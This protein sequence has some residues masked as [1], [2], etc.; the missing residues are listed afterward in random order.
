MRRLRLLITRKHEGPSRDDRVFVDTH[1]QENLFKVT[2]VNPDEAS[3]KEFVVSE[4]QTLNYLG[5]ILYSLSRD[6][7]PFEKIQLSS[8]IHPCVIYPI[9]DLFDGD[10]REL[11]MNMIRDAL[12][13]R[14]EG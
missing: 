12:R 3:H 2:F 6:T 10:I 7:D 1:G 14:I 4:V 8:S 9:A 5:D 13:F 11:I